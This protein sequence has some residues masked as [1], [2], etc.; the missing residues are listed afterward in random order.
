MSV[1]VAWLLVAV[2]LGLILFRGRFWLPE[3][4]PAP[5]DPPA[6]PPVVALIPAR[7]EAPVIGEAVRSLLTQDYPGD[8][9]VILIDDQSGDGTGMVA[10][11]AAEAAG[12]ADRLTLVP[13]APLPAGWTGKLWALEQATRTA[14][15]LHPD[16]PLWLLTDADIR[17]GGGEV[18]RMVAWLEAGKLDIASL[19]VRLSTE[20][21]AERAI[22]PAF[23]YFF[24]LLYPFRKVAD[25]GDRTAAAAGGFVLIR[26]A[27]LEGIGGIAAIRGALID[28]CTL[29]AAVKA[30]GGPI[31]LGLAGAT[32]SIRR[33]GWGELWRMIARSAYTQLHHSPLLLLG[34]VAGM[35]F[36]FAGPVALT[37]LGGAASI[38]AALAWLAMAASVWPTLRYYRL[39]PAWAPLLPLV[40]LFYLGATVDSARRHW[41]GRGGQWKGRIQAGH[42]EV[43]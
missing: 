42:G 6:W 28:D 35:L 33:Y 26:R 8:L 37:V 21:L 15:A 13:G 30:K 19:M 10:R 34:T 39:S 20:S 29:A 41:Q 27:A 4:L 22:V 3:R 7:D 2:W 36:A 38:P 17:H 9:R 23:V 11:A 40:A 31:W 16:V 5:S 14:R 25:P 1:F 24:R 43:A 32:E 12:A 18:R